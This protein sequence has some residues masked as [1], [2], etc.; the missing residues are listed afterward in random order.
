MPCLPSGARIAWRMVANPDETVMKSGLAMTYRFG[1]FE[2]CRERYELRR[3]RALVSLEP[4][5][6]EVLAYLVSHH[7]R[8]VPKH[9]L[10]DQLWAGQAVSEAALTR[11]IREAR[12]AL[13]GSWIKTVYGRGFRFVG[14]VLVGAPAPEASPGRHAPA[15]PSVAVLPFADL[16]P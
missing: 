8:V 9:E 2:L 15:L 5:V 16:S 11:T 3:G 4:R 12:R 1:T 10:L 6:L 14:P 13:R 7:D